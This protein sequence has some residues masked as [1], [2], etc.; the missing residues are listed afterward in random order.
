ML[1]YL[2]FRDGRD[3][4]DHPQH[5]LYTGLAQKYA[6][7]LGQQCLDVLTDHWDEIGPEL[8]AELNEQGDAPQPGSECSPS[9]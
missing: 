5:S 2:Y 1:D 3:N 7:S 9:T 8:L 4:P 6:L